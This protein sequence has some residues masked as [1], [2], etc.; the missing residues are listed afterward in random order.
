MSPHAPNVPVVRVGDACSVHASFECGSWDCWG[1]FMPIRRGDLLDHLASTS[2]A[3]VAVPRAMMPF[4]PTLGPVP[5]L[6]PSWYV[7]LV[8]QAE[9]IELSAFAEIVVV[10]HGDP[11][12]PEDTTL[13]LFL[14]TVEEARLSPPIGEQR[15]AA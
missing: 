7:F 4:R 11:D 5:L 8:S 15:V 14:P 9:S 1:C 3:I 2:R 12:L 6:H 13:F 10:S